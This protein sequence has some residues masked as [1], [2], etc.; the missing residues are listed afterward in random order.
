MKK[1]SESSRKYL[2]IGL[3][4][5][6]FILSGVMIYL[7]AASLSSLRTQVEEEELAVENAR[8]RLVRLNQHRANAAEY[9]ERLATATRLVPADPEED[10]LLRYIHRLADQFDLRAQSISFGGRSQAEGYTVMPL[11]INVQGSYRDIQLLLG[12]LRNGERAIRVDSFNVTR[13]AEAGAP[14]NVS[15]NANAFYSNNTQ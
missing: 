5:L 1:M 3:V 9:E 15:I 10:E 14:L 2:I 6:V 13:G 7:Q 12:Q 4:V 8:A 11:S